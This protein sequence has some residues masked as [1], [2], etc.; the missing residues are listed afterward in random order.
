MKYLIFINLILLSFAYSKAQ[1]ISDNF[2]SYS[3]SSL[4][5]SQ[6]DGLWTTSDNNPGGI[7]DVLISNEN[8]YSAN[9]SILFTRSSTNIIL[10]LN[11]IRTETWELSFKMLI[12]PGGA[13]NFSVSHKPVNGQ[14]N[15]AFDAS[16]TQTGAGFLNAANS[17]GYNFTHPVGE[18]FDVKV[19]IKPERN[20]ARLLIDD[21]PIR[22]SSWAWCLGSL[23]KDSTIT[24]LHFN[25]VAPEV[26]QIKYY[27]D[28]VG[29]QQTNLQL[30]EHK[31]TVNV[32]PIPASQQVIIETPNSQVVACEIFSILGAV[33]YKTTVTS[34]QFV[35]DCSSWKPGIYLTK[36]ESSNKRVWHTK[37]I[38][39]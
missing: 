8:S 26:G 36:L 30:E 15:T 28:D 35:I 31:N 29:F 3:A 19:E 16:F 17:V 32:Y 33:V 2:D 20:Q 38:V 24:A 1:S 5:C 9:N 34:E 6:S 27:I 25:P 22:S 13:G 37:F 21:I 18:W 10:P 12:A 7:R 11:D 14:I 23:G 4:L 39:E